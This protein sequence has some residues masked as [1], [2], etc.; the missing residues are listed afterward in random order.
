MEVV[1]EVAD[2]CTATVR[3]ERGAD[4][5]R[6]AIPTHP[7]EGVVVDQRVWS[8]WTT[9]RH[10]TLRGGHGSAHPMIPQISSKA[11]VR[12]REA[13]A[14]EGVEAVILLASRYVP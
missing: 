1:S 4:E 3:L 9:A 5:A 14:R 12:C 6:H 8:A 11:T 7:V 2:E 10:K 13:C